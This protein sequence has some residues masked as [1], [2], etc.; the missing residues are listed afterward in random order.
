MHTDIVDTPLEN[1]SIT[2]EPVLDQAADEFFS[3]PKASIR[4]KQLISDW[5]PI[6]SKAVLNRRKRYLDLDVEE[7]RR[8]GVINED[9]TFTPD[10]IIDTNILRETPDYISFLKQSHR[11]AIF[12]C[13]DDPRINTT[14][15]E[16]EFTEGMTYKGWYRPFKRLID[17]A[18]LHGW[19][20]IEVM[21]DIDKPLHVGFEYV[22]NDRLFFNIGINDIQNSEYVVREYDVSVMQ[23]ESFVLNFGFDNAQVESITQKSNAGR[24]KR[25]EIVKIYK[26]LFKFTNCVYVAWYSQDAQQND[27]LKAPE[28]LRMGVSAPQQTPPPNSATSSMTPNALPMPDPSMPPE[29]TAMQPP[30]SPMMAGGMPQP[31]QEVDMDMYPMFVYLYKDDE[32]ECIV[33][34]K[35][36]AFL[37]EATQEATTAITT[38]FVNSTV[39]SSDIYA[40][41]DK[42]NDETS[43]EI[44]Q[45]NVTL[46]HGGIYN[47]PLR[48]F[49]MPPPD[50]SMLS[51]LNF[52]SSRNAQQSGKVDMAVINRKDSRKTAQ[53]L[54]Q[55]EGETDKISSTNISDFSEYLRDVYGFSW[56]IVQSQAINNEV[57][58]MLIEQPNTV[59]L[60]GQQ[61]EI[62][63]TSLVNDVATLQHPYDIRPSGDVDVIQRAETLVNMQNDWPVV[64]N[65]PLA[66]KFMLDFVSLRYP[67]QASTYRKILEEGDPAKQLIMSLT[68]LLQGFAQPEEIA[69]LSPEAKQQLVMIQ[70]QVQAYLG[71]G[72][73]QPPQGKPQPTQPQQ[74]QPQVA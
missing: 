54:K 62:G 70:Q 29:L 27:W 38:A 41:P 50:P 17:G 14:R 16:D 74:A 23:L 61:I 3:Y 24:R 32:Q 60:N 11:L 53:E 73:Q 49:H 72:E 13:I 37:D 34:H 6:R 63:G 45:L 21:F 58:F 65:T 4:I 51:S 20:S 47:Q 39:R 9:E 5:S 28:K 40:S 71:N 68:T 25:D 44:A 10:R 56:V 2:P 1:A 43:G 57:P 66:P 12:K 46:T 7:M 31:A 22:A 18:A 52:L 33:E 36:R 15:L 55:A 67:Q 64:Q 69:A 42:E 8:K 48:F 26:V 19:A 30:V 35:G 59:N